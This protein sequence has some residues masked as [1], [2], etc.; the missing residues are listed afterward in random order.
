MPRLEFSAPYALYSETS[1]RN[2]E[3]LLERFHLPRMHGPGGGSYTREEFLYRKVWNYER[4]A[5]PTRQDWIFAVGPEAMDFLVQKQL[6][7]SGMADE[8]RVTLEKLLA[9]RPGHPPYLY[10]LALLVKEEDPVRALGL[11][12]RAV[13]ARPK[14]YSYVFEVARLNFVAG[15]ARK[16][17]KGFHAARELPHTVDDEGGLLMYLVQCYGSLGMRDEEKV[18]QREFLRANL[19]FQA[20]PGQR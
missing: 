18:A 1:I 10:D 20:Q 3:L 4:L 16:A 9:M 7:Q 5:I 11:L 13:A 2:T 15:D 8:A 12:E 6:A 19:Y 17:L 14:E